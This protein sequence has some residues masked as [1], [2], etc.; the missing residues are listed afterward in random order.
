MART[1]CW[2]VGKQ[3]TQTVAQV[4]LVVDGAFEALF[5]APALIELVCELL[6]SALHEFEV[7]PRVVVAFGAAPDGVCEPGRAVAID[8]DGP[9]RLLGS[10]IGLGGQGQTEIE[11]GSIAQF[12]VGAGIVT[13]GEKGIGCC[14][15][16]AAGEALAARVV[17]LAGS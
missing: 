1:A 5:E 9:L 6:N 10:G 12:R 14:T 3:A 11:G 13:G 7:D 15:R 8:A 2:G 17:A 4:A 16:V